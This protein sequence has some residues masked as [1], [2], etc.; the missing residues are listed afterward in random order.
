MHKSIEPFLEALKTWATQRPD[1]FA[2]AIVGSY[3]RGMERPD[4]A[5]DVILIVDDPVRYLTTSAW[6]ELFGQVRLIAHEDWGCCNRD[7]F[8]T[9]M[10]LRWN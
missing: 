3:A 1:I 7:A 4:S 2:V 6:L 8:A 5:I 10:E 9:P